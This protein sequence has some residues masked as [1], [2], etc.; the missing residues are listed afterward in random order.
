ML[1]ASCGFLLTLFIDPEYVALKYRLTFGRLHSVILQKILS[2][3]FFPA[4]EETVCLT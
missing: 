4:L 3:G 2:F 1:P